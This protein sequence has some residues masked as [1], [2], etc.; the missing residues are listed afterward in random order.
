MHIGEWRQRYAFLLL[1]LPAFSLLSVF[2]IIPVVWVVRVSFYLNVPGE[3]MKAAWTLANY[4]RAAGDQWFVRN[5]YLFSFN[6]A[7]ATTA[8]AILLGYPLS[9]YIAMSRGLKRQLL[10]TLTLSPLLIGMVCLIFGWI[11]IFRGHGILNQFTIW[12]GIT[13]GEVK[14]LYSLKVIAMA[15]L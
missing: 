9:L 6:I 14:Y 10:L 15:Y 7:V 1:I 4:A 13:S 2:L 8:L 5:V 12:T 3:Y 11:I